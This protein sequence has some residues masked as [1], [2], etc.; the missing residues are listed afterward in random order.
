[1]NTHRLGGHAPRAPTIVALAVTLAST[2]TALGAEEHV[3][4]EYWS[5]AVEAVDALRQQGYRIIGLEKTSASVEIE[6]LLDRVPA[7]G[8]R[9][10]MG[11]TPRTSKRFEV[12]RRPRTRS[13]MPSPV[14]LRFR[15]L[16][17]ASSALGV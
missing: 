15:R 11:G 8:P 2:G 16:K 17:A 12:M 5:R 14:R 10:R 4:W 7:D 9:P 6:E 13:A 3:A 1:M